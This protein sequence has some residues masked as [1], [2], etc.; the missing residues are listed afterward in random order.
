MDS[1]FI[2]KAFWSYDNGFTRWLGYRQADQ[3]PELYQTAEFNAQVAELLAAQ[4]GL[5][6]AGADVAVITDILA[7]ER[8]SANLITEGAPEVMVDLANGDKVMLESAEAFANLEAVAAGLPA[9][10]VQAATDAATAAG[11][12]YTAHLEAGV[13]VFSWFFTNLIEAA[14]NLMYVLTHLGSVLNWVTW[15]GSDEE[16]KSL[17]RF[18]YYGASEELFFVLLLVLLVLLGIGFARRSFMWG[19]VRALEGFGNAVGRVAA[20]AGLIM[21]LQQ[22]MIILLQRIFA[23]SDISLG[24]GMTFT[25]PVSWWGEQL[26][27]YNAMIVTLCISYTF[28][29]GGHVRV[30]LVYSAISFRAK[31]VIDM[32]GSIFLMLPAAILIWLYS[33][34]F[35][36]RHLINP[37][38]NPTIEL[39]TLVENRWRG[40]RWNLETIGFS[41]NGFNAY[42]LFKILLVLFVAMV[43]LQAIAFFCR[44]YLEWREGPESEGKYLD[45]DK[46]GDETAELAA[47]IH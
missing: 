32:L 3:S 40:V 24:F 36:W 43:I 37:P 13:N 34:F 2:G 44:S 19:I 41:P 35:M 42:F 15:T 30:D 22:I 27:L 18:A 21:V 45:K 26:K 28:V 4:D 11:E 47:N 9:E 14:Y 31:R 10:S 5:D 23:V 8:V 38:L 39:S 20:W 12:A 33:W 7:G 1:T 17:M 25:F 16:K 6:L 29:Q 46:L